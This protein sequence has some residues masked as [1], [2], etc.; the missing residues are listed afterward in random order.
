[1]ID[2][3]LLVSRYLKQVPI[4]GV[5]VYKQIGDLRSNSALWASTQNFDTLGS[6]VALRNETSESFEG[7]YKVRYF[8][9]NYS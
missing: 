2:D 7:N 3:K 6:G 5:G 8:I 1:M 4:A 9:L